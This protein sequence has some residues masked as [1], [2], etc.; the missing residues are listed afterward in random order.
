VIHNAVASTCLGGC[1]GAPVND[2]FL[3]VNHVGLASDGLNRLYMAVNG[4]GVYRYTISTHASQLISTGGSDPNTGAPLTFAFVG[5]AG[6]M[7]M[8]DRLGNLWI[9]DD[10]SDGRFNFNGR[11]WYISA[12]QLAT[13]P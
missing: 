6:N 4:A 9:G 13:L 5:G 12:G 3:G 7:V 11:I 2:G 1:N 8:L 10:I